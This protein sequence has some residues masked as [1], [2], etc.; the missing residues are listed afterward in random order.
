MFQNSQ[1]LLL[2]ALDSRCDNLNQLVVKLHEVQVT[3]DN[4]GSLAETASDPLVLA[5]TENCK[6]KAKIVFTGTDGSK[7]QLREMP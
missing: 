6:A 1:G 5:L 3:Y 2:F 4:N 7:R